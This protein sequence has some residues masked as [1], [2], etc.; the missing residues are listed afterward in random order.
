MSPTLR[1][2]ACMH[3]RASCESLSALIKMDF[4]AVDDIVDDNCDMIVVVCLVLVH[5]TLILSL[6]QLMRS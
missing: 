3:K 4:N 1:D 6:Q 5:L 2:L